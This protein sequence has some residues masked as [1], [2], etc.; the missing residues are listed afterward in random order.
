[1]LRNAVA[2]RLSVALPATAIFDYPTPASLAAFVATLVAPMPVLMA[3]DSTPSVTRSSQAGIAISAVSS[4]FPGD[5]GTGE[6]ATCSVWFMILYKAICQ[7]KSQEQQGRSRPDKTQKG[8]EKLCQ[9]S[10]SEFE[11]CM[12]TR[13]VSAL[14]KLTLDYQMLHLV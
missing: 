8:S 12:C 4:R 2:A 3:A 1:M 14:T 6:S 9:C 5:N 11:T 13:V 10:P 7:A